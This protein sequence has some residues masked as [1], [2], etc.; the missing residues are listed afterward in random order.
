MT[1]ECTHSHTC[2]STEAHTRVQHTCTQSPVH[3][4][5]CSHRHPQVCTCTHAHPS[6]DAHGCAHTHAHKHVSP[7]SVRS[8]MLQARPL[9]CTLT[10][11]GP[12]CCTLAVQS[13]LRPCQVADPAVD[14]SVRPP[15]FGSS[16]CL[17]SVARPPQVLRGAHPWGPPGPLDPRPLPPCDGVHILPLP[18]LP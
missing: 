15:G 14:L 3:T 17:L 18:L 8:R 12:P 9:P 4:H 2:N 5:T 11:R 6:T 7:A 13:L 10:P 16:S 1:C